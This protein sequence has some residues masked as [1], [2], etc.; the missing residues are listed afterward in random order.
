MAS[1]K[2]SFKN[3]SGVPEGN[4]K[5]VTHIIGFAGCFSNPVPVAH[6]VVWFSL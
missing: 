3:L 5:T 6:T 4:H 2:V 1:L